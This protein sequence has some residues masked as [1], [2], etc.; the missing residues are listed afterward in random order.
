MAVLQYLGHSAFYLQGNKIR[1]L[2][3][4]FL[5]GN[6]LASEGAEART[7]LDY[8]FV[9][10]AHGDHLGDAL[11]IAGRTEA[12]V[13]ATVE[14]AAYL[15]GKGLKTEGMNI[16]GKVDFPF[17]KVKLLPAFHSSSIFEGDKLVCSDTPCGFLLE[18]E[19]KKIYHSGD[20]GLS[21]EMNL[22]AAE[23]VEIALVPIGGHYVMD[24]ARA[25]GFIRPRKVVPMHYDTFPS[26]KADPADFARKL[27]G[28]AEVVIMKPG[29]I[30]PF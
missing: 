15:A 22:L 19:G 18:I 11:A 20:T 8:I 1:A 6:P 30:L 9:S 23:D 24:A 21:V 28:E 13:V 2:I 29:D 5:S 12:V 27:A 4:P 26:I 17:G 7:E 25:V 16:G 14:L 3:D 10:H